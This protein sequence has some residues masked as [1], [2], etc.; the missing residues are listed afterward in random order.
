MKYARLRQ[1]CLVAHDLEPPARQLIDSFGLAEAHREPRIEH[2]GLQNVII[3]IGATPV[4]IEIVAPIRPDT[5]AGRFLARRGGDAGYMFIADCDDLDAARARSAAL[6]LRTISANEW[7]DDPPTRSFQLHPR[8]TGAAIVE[9]DQHG[10]GAELF[11]PYRWAGRDWQGAVRREPVAAVK[12]VEVQSHRPLELATLWSA[13]FDAALVTDASGDPAFDLDN[14]RVV[15]PTAPEGEEETLSAL[16]LDVTDPHLLRARA[17]AAGATFAG[18]D[19]VIC[20]VRF[21]VGG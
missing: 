14:V 3:P 15:F 2:L 13:L 8:D 4:F 18:D 17:R 12:T 19:P 6:G 20:G 7:K 1:I 9:I 21:A 11:G 10:A 5:A 16:R